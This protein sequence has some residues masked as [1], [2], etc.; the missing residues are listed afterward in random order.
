MHAT[1]SETLLHTRIFRR[2]ARPRVWQVAAESGAEREVGECE[3][4]VGGERDGQSGG[5]EAECRGDGDEVDAAADVLRRERRRSLEPV[6]SQRECERS[7]QQPDAA[8][9]AHERG[10]HREHKRG[11]QPARAS[12]LQESSTASTGCR[13]Y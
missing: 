13:A 7:A 5:R 9:R 8:P 3:D 10:K 12:L 6:D 1:A 4:V 2:E 11:E